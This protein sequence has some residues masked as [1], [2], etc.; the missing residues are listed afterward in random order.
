MVECQTLGLTG[1]PTY[2]PGGTFVHPRSLYPQS[3]IDLN[4]ENATKKQT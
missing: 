2:Y 1:Y 3:E 4:P